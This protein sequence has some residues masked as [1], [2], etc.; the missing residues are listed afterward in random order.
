MPEFTE[1]AAVFMP[2]KFGRFR[3]KLVEQTLSCGPV[4]RVDTLRFITGDL[5]CRFVT[6]SPCR[7]E[8]DR[9]QQ[10]VTAERRSSLCGGI[11]GGRPFISC[12]DKR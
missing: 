9:G 4:L 11:S 7:Q 2:S 8:N 3:E 5:G 10:V 1:N 12:K 6:F